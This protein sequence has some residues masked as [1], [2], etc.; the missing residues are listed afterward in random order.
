MTKYQK[1]KPFYQVSLKE[2][3]GP[4]G[5]EVKRILEVTV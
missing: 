2:V 1:G 3:L 4:P 5:Y